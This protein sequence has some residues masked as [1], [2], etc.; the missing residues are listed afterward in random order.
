MTGARTS[1]NSHGRLK[2]E[3]A[4][5]TRLLVHEDILDYS[6]HVS[7]RVPGRD[8][9]FIQHGVD[10]RSEVRPER[11]LMVDFDGN[12]LEGDGRAPIETPIHGEIYRAR[13]DVN[14]VLHCHMELAIAFTLM[15]DVTLA[16]MRARAVRWQSGIPTSPDPSHIKLKEQGE[17]LARDLGP[18][19]AV[20]MRAHGLTLVAESVPALLVDAVHFDENAR[21]LMQVL[22]AGKTPVPL[23]DEEMTQINK[24]E[25]RDFHVGK[26]WSYYTRRGQKAGVLED[27]WEFRD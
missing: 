13:P 4:A 1:S 19:H 17:A 27:E 8:A 25:V 7:V 16:P 14:A 10:P 15:K 20:L 3:A 21:A 9:Y 6:G 23:T 12:V 2:L 24:H 18:H 5:A 22:Q 26:L 11:M